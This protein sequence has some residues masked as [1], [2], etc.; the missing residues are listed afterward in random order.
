M[1]DAPPPSTSFQRSLSAPGTFAVVCAE[2]ALA[3]LAPASF[4]EVPEAPGPCTSFSRSFS[5][6]FA[7]FFFSFFGSFASASFSLAFSLVGA[8]SAI[9]PVWATSVRSISS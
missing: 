3:E 7:F 6:S 9:F 1:E 2:L 5:F 8:C 4:A